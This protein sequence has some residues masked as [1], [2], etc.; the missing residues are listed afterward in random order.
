M[1]GQS[2]FVS[3]YKECD[4]AVRQSIIKRI[5]DLIIDN[6]SF[7]NKQ[8]YHVMCNV[9]TGIAIYKVLSGRVKS[10]EEVML[11]L[12]G[13]ASKF[14]DKEKKKFVHLMQTSGFIP[15]FHKAVCDYAVKNAGY[16]WKLDIPQVSG[17]ECHVI[18]NQCLIRKL[19]CKYNVESMAA[20]FCVMNEF[21]Y[22]R[23]S[24]PDFACSENMCRNGSHCD[25]SVTEKAIV[26]G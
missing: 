4:E 26:N 5:E 22:G 25:F 16:G 19:C 12:K 24:T 8:N 2:M 14:A 3:I 18:I 6:P 11:M 17:N 13:C 10:S 9:I 1:I 7:T 21:V 23:D 20:I 15:K